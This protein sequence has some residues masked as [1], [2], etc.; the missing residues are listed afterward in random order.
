[1]AGC[2]IISHKVTNGLPRHF[3]ANLRYW[4][5]VNLCAVLSGFVAVMVFLKK[6]AHSYKRKKC[7]AS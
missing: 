4:N 1:M 6:L 7:I 3:P 5:R 2:F